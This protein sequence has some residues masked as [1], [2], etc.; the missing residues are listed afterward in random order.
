MSNRVYPINSYQ[1]SQSDRLLFDA[2]IW[3]YLYGPEFNA[4][5]NRTITYSI[6]LRKA[7]AAKSQLF[8]DPLI[9]SEFV[10]SYGRTIYNKLPKGSKPQEFKSFRNSPSFQPIS[11][12]IT[13]DIKTILKNCHRIESGWELVDIERIFHDFQ[14]GKSDFNDLM[15]AQ[16]CQHQ[17]LKLVTHDADFQ[18]LDVTILTA[19]SRLVNP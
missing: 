1:F 13:K 3:L 15:L 17:N 7:S 12:R 9:V 2:N 6:A 19:N 5:D 14:T 18:G 11:Q 4:K 8:I 10:N 16:L